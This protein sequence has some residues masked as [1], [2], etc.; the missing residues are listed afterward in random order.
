MKIFLDSANLKEIKEAIDLGICDG[1]TT[2]PSL[3]VKEGV[4]NA[5]QIAKICELVKGP[6]NAETISI[7][8]EGII[9]EGRELASIASNVVVKIPMSK[10]GLKAV[11]AFHEEGI[12]TTVTL[13]F[14]ASQ[15]VL[16]ARAG[17]DFIAPFVGRLDD[18][19]NEGMNLIADI[20]LIYGN[21]GYETE[22]V[23]ASVRNPLHFIESAR[24]GAD[25]ITLPFAMLEKLFGHP[26]TDAGIAKFLADAEKTKKNRTQ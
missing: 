22:V 25:I 11:R 8:Y 3:I 17:A 15:A 14:N 19:S 5:V 1:I 10:D 6:V 12:P 21:Y 16:A 23:V 13:I 2:N 18:I 24:I 7:N 9:K 4:E 26:L 20:V